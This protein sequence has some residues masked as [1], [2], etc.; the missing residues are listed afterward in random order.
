[1]SLS[2]TPRAPSRIASR[3]WSSS[4]PAVSSTTRV[5][6]SPASRVRRTERPSPPACGRRAPGRRD[7]A[8]GRARSGVLAV[9]AARHHRH[10]LLE[11]EELL[12]PVEDDGVI[13]GDHHPDGAVTPPLRCRPAAGC[14]GG[15]RRRSTP[16]PGLPLSD[17]TRSR[18]VL[19]PASIRASASPV[20]RPANGKPRPLSRTEIDTSRARG[21]ATIAT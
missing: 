6:S 17:A 14:R 10:P 13:V 8:G 18:S 19:G 2:T 11:A 7:G 16:P 4:T 1:M 12:E 15:R 5:G 21:H 9:A 3:S 20:K